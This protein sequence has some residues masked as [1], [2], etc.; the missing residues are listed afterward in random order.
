VEQAAVRR[1]LASAIDR[2]VIIKEL[3]APTAPAV[4]ARDTLI[5]DQDRS[6][7][8]ASESAS[9]DSLAAAGCADGDDGVLVCDGQRMALR[10]VLGDGHWQTPVVAEYVADHLERIGV[11][12]AH[13]GPAAPGAGAEPGPWDL[14]VTTIDP[15]GA[16]GLDGVRWRCDDVRNDQGYCSADLDAVLQRAATTLEAGPRAALLD[17]AEAILA[18]D[19][20]TLPLHPV[21]IMVVRDEGVSGPALNGPP[22]SVLWNAAAW[23]ATPNDADG[24]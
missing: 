15:S 16:A 17:E 21:P 8:G 3:V 12:V 20:P 6:T 14:R 13:P 18:R 2:S 7:P 5:V 10:L 1:A 9:A 4:G 23:S 19:R 24:R 22:W 11:D